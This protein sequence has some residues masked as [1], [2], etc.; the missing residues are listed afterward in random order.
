VPMAG[1]TDAWIFAEMAA[2]LGVPVSAASMTSLRHAYLAHLRRELEAPV[3]GKRVLPGI[4]TLLD[5][6]ASI[7]TVSLGLLTG[8]SAEGARI[9]LDHF[10]LWRYFVAGGFGDRATDRNVVYTEAIAAVA[11]A[12]GVWFPPEN[13]VVVGDTPHD[14]ATAKAGGARC[15]AVATGSF[16]P[17]ALRAAGAEIVLPDLSDLTGTLAAL[18]IA[19][20]SH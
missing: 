19:L 10:D 4:R 6:L 16:A 13:T 14:V 11:A 9:K 8:N 2:L 7:P 12:T 1:R 20:P 15:V 18:G 5:R 3:P 17:D